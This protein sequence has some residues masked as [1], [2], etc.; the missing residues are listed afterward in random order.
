MDR[1][2]LT[3]SN[4]CKYVS[5]E[6]L[7]G[8]LID[9]KIRF[10]QPGAFNDPFELVPLLLVPKEIVSQGYRSYKFDLT[11]PRRSDA[12]IHAR[13]GVDRCNDHHSRELRQALDREVG[14]L[15][16]SKTWKSLPMWGHYADGYAGAVIEFDGDHEFFDWAFDIQYSSHRPVRDL[17]LYLNA[18]IPIAELCEKSIEWEFEQEVRVARALSD[19][20]F[21]RQSSDFPVFVV[22]IP[23][24]CI[25]RVILGER[26][27]QGV[28]MEI[29]RLIEDTAIMGDRAVVNHWDYNLELGPL[30]IG[31]YQSGGKTISSPALRNYRDYPSL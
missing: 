15:S 19:C 24:Q 17:T 11:A 27:D 13:V 18:P 2:H 12:V 20:K 16:L 22:D 10:T 29:F 5:I 7:R 6:R 9:H 4:L 21:S 14:F 28:A 3:M 25:K 26:V 23:P 30:K 1:C 8:I 31:P